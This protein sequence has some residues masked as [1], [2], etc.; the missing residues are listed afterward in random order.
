MA[1]E[2]MFKEGKEELDDGNY[3]KAAELLQQSVD[4]GYIT[5]RSL[6]NLAK[7]YQNLGKAKK[8]VKYFDMVVEKFPDS[9]LV[10]YAKGRADTLRDDAAGTGEDEDSDAEGTGEESGEESAEN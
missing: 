2:P 3:D 7:A 4:Y 1:A 8:A 6:Y 10:D 5:D 9:D